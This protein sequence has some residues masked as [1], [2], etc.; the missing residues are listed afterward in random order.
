MFGRFVG[1]VVSAVAALCLLASPADAAIEADFNGDG[2]LDRIVLPRPPE[3]NIVVR[4]SG[5]APQVLKLYD[6]VISIVAT[7]IDHDGEVD[8]SALSERRGVFVWLNKGK[9]SNGHLKA[10]KRQHHRRGF[11]LTTHGPLASA[12]ESSS[13]GPAATGTQDDRDR[14]ACYERGAYELSQRPAIGPRSPVLPPLSDPHAGA[15]PSRAPPAL[16]ASA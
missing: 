8:L 2:V 7:D 6:R 11:A 10:L 4:L 9:G 13:D 12:P 15:C 14:S 3:T 5:G 1:R 16:P